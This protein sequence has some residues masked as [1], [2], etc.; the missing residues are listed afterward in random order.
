ME[1]DTQQNANSDN[2]WVVEL[3]VTFSP[4]NFLIFF[5]FSTVNIYCICKENETEI[6]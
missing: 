5:K 6:N 3:Q 4:Q 2:F 1:K